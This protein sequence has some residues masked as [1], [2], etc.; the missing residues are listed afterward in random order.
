MRSFYHKTRTRPAAC[1]DS[2]LRPLASFRRTEHGSASII[3]AA[4]LLLLAG[5]FSLS[6]DA[7]YLYLSRRRLQAAVDFAALKA[8]T[9]LSNATTR[10]QSAVEDNVSASSLDG[11]VTVV[12]GRYPPLG[13]TTATLSTLPVDARFEPAAAGPNAVRVSAHVTVP[14]YLARL[15]Y[16]SGAHVFAQ[17]TAYNT[18]LTQLEVGTGALS[19]D[20]SQSAIFNALFSGLLGASVNLNAVSYQGL[21]DTNVRLFDFLDAMAAL[22]G[23]APGD[24]EALIGATVTYTNVLEALRTAVAADPDLASVAN[25]VTTTLS[26]FESQTASAGSFRLGNILNISG[27]DS[28]KAVGSVVNVLAMVRAAAEGVN[29]AA[30]SVFPTTLSIAGGTVSLR[31]AVVEPTQMSAVGGA[32]ITASSAQVRIYAEVDPTAALNILGQPVSVRFPIYIESLSG[33]ATVTS[34]TCAAADASSAEVD[35]TAQSGPASASTADVDTTSLYQTAPLATQPAQVSYAAGLVK[36]TANG[37]ETITG[38]SQD[39]TFVAP[40]D[41]SDTQRVP[42][43]SPLDTVMSSVLASTNFT[44][45][46]LGVSFPSSLVTSQ[47]G[48]ILGTVASPVDSLIDELLKAF[49]IQTAYTDVTVP[50]VRCS[51]PTLAQ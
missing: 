6:V 27:N 25:A 16:G 2:W 3:I 45:S 20:T 43:T 31:L 50:Y 47:L 23:T 49:G 12:E 1:R 8:V 18:P 40:F 24:Y 48:P 34:L 39:L 36:V 51:N 37:G 21:A 42:L 33:R 28:V 46:A 44:V 15:F 9:D 26:N 19:I 29:T 35:V 38:D 11:P 41:S 10:A 22:T 7:G 30:G 13:Y 4:V 17:A 14:L 32:G 5:I